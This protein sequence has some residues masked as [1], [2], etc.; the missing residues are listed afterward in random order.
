MLEKYVKNK[1]T[2]PHISQ[3][4]TALFGNP[5][6]SVKPVAFRPC[7]AAGL[8]FSPNKYIGDNTYVNSNLLIYQ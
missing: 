8:A 7:F 2:V 4:V 3:V 1:K 6:V 5:A